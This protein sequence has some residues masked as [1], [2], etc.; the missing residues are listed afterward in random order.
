MSVMLQGTV[1]LLGLVFSVQASEERLPELPDFNTSAASVTVVL[2]AAQQSNAGASDLSVHEILDAM[3]ARPEHYV[4]KLDDFSSGLAPV[5]VVTQSFLEGLTLPKPLLDSSPD[6][7]DDES[8]HVQIS[9]SL[10]VGGSKV[11]RPVTKR[12]YASIDFLDQ[13]DRSKDPDVI[14]HQSIVPKIRVVRHK[15]A[16]IACKYVRCDRVYVPVDE[17]DAHQAKHSADDKKRLQ[18]QATSKARWLLKK[19]Q[20]TTDT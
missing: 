12:H 16:L 5:K 15:A 10:V 19:Q 8:E 2:L 6:F 17:W 13:D 18:E 11:L 7:S 1:L 3:L 14:V 4:H 9:E 20:G